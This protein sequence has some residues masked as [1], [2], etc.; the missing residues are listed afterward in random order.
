MLTAVSKVPLYSLGKDEQNYVKH[1]FL[2][3]MPLAT[4][5]ASHSVYGIINGATV[6]LM[7][8]QSKWGATWMF[9]SCDAIDIS[10]GIKR[11]WWHCQW[12]AVFLRSR[13]PKWS[14]NDFLV[15]WH[16]CCLHC[17]LMLPTVS[18]VASL[19]STQSNWDTTWIFWLW[20]HCH[21]HHMKPIALP[22]AHG[23]DICTGTT[24]WWHHQ[25]H[26]FA[27]YITKTNMLFKCHI[28]QLVHM[29]IWHICV[30]IHTPYE[31]NAINIENR[32]SGIHTF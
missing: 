28:Y 7:G 31:P 29:H 12:H 5:L 13:P 15:M 26:V 18:S 2:V 8:R 10:I 27:M 21:W 19:Q 24:T 17:H 20:C 25:H 9:W 16:H 4:V 6:F 1:Y 3:V 22:M 14:A 32:N 30:S 23:T 11:C